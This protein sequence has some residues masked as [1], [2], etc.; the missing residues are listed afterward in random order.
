MAIATLEW[1]TAKEAAGLAKV[2]EWTIYQ[3]C[4]RGEL[5]HVRIG[6]RRAIRV[7][8]DGVHEWLLRHECV[9]PATSA[10]ARSTRQEP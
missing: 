2:S 6:G 8:R 10:E 5:R 9:P 1:L 7:T 3:A 4:E